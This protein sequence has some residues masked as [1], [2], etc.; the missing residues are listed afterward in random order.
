VTDRRLRDLLRL[1]TA[2][3]A[4]FGARVRIE[5]TAGSHIKSTFSVGAREGFIVSAFTPGDWRYARKVRADAR[6]VLRNLSA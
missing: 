2:E 5:K 4:P 3:A 6:R 1:L